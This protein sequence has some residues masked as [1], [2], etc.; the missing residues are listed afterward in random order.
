MLK[1]LKVFFIFVG[2]SFIIYF[3]Y[4]FNILNFRASF[5][6]DIFLPAS[7]FFE[8]QV[9]VG[10][11]SLL[12]KIKILE[13][14][15]KTNEFEIS[16]LRHELQTKVDYTKLNI[17]AKIISYEGDQIQ[18]NHGSSSGI[19][20][21][22]LVIVGNNLIGNVTTT[23]KNKSLISLLNSPLSKN[24]CSARQGSSN[25]WGILTGGGDG[26][27]MLTKISDERKLEINTSVYCEGFLAGKVKNIKKEPSSLFYEAEIEVSVNA[28]NLDTVYVLIEK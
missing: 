6:F 1:S 15:K 2:L 27:V 21:K 24:Y 7:Y 11:N 9:N 14:D 3:C 20:E 19:L 4:F 23:A 28:Q 8:K 18:V 12:E 16:R 5:L 17:E 25:I 22:Q 13:N 26:K 10:N